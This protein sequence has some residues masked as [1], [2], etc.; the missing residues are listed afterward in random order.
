MMKTIC[1]TGASGG[2]GEAIAK[3]LAKQNVKLI[4]TGRN[5]NNLMKVVSYIQNN[6]QS[7]VLP[8]VFDVQDLDACQK[9][10]DSI[11]DSF[12]DID[13][14]INNAGLAVELNPIHQGNFEDWERMI[15][16]NIKGLLYVSR[17]IVPRMVERKSG[18]IIN[19][20]STASREVYYGGNVYC[21]TKHAVLA[22][23]QAMRADLLP[24]HIKVTQI[25]PGAAETNF[26]VVRFH[27]DQEKADKVYEGYDP[28]VAQDIADIVEFVLSRPPHVCLN[29][30][31]VTPTAQFNGKIHKD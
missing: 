24:Y 23:S 5:E 8:L 1:I 4:L 9:A 19:I 2:F 3:T 31:I 7:Q 12:K 28:L 25:A 15:N 21:A 13:V 30:I 29:E 14:L 27:G 22:L 11:P 16:T 20:G 26:S 17:L 18:H 10:V 6:T